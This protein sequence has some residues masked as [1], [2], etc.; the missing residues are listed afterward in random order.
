MATVLREFTSDGTRAALP[1]AESHIVARFGVQTR[2]SIDLHAIGARERVHRKDVRAGMRVVMS[3]LPLASVE[4][5]LGISA[6]ALAGSIVPLEDLWG[7]PARDLRDRLAAAR[8]TAEAATLVEHAIAARSTPPRSSVAS[9]AAT[10]LEHASVRTVA[11]DLG[12]SERQLRRVFHAA[13]GVSPKAFARLRRFHRAV[14][15]ARRGTTWARIAASTGYCDQAHLID[16]FRAIA[17]TTPRAFLGELAES[18][19]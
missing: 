3:R 6:A 14:E 15:A 5:V 13:I 16:D 11:R 12:V 17:G 4:S 19:A 1:H 10:K 9:L 8:T 18:I 2:D 7:G